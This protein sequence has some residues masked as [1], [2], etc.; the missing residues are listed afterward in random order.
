MIK[1]LERKKSVLMKTICLNTFPPIKNYQESVEKFG[2][3][4]ISET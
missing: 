1:P 4:I 3:L 2:G